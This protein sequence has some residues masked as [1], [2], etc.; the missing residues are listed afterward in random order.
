MDSLYLDY[1]AR[2]VLQ[3]V[4]DLVA[5]SKII[6]KEDF[7][8]SNWDGGFYKGTQYGIPANECFVR[9]ALC[10]NGRMV[11][12]AGLDP[13]TPPETWSEVL[14]WHTK[15]TKFDTAGNLTQIGLDPYDSIGG[16]MNPIDGFFAVYP[17]VSSSLT[18]EPASSISTTRKWQ[19]SLIRMP[20]FTR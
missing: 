11:E 18:K 10:Y 16:S 20:S 17:G 12:K 7:I 9:Y 13:K 5:T 1:M 2:G 15:L 19:I 14:D 3:S 4:G 8:Q 6:K